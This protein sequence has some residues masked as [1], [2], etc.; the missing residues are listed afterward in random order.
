MSRSDMAQRLD[1]EETLES[2]F[3]QISSRLTVM[4]R[5][6]EE[7]WRRLDQTVVRLEGMIERV[8]RR[9]WTAAAACAAVGA[10]AAVGVLAASAPMVF[11]G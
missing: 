2:D 1:D 9:I 3:D 10:S 5:L 6:S 8:D 4:E 7:R 11:G